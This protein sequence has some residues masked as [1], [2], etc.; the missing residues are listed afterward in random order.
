M[1]AVLLGI[2]LLLGLAGAAPAQTQTPAAVNGCIYYSSLP[3][4]AN[5]QR[6][7]FLC[8]V[9]GKLLTTGSGGGGSGTVTSVGW[10][11]GLVS[12]ATPTTTPAFTVAGTSGG[13]PYFSSAS[14]WASSA[15]LAANALVVGGGAGVAP[16]TTTTGTGVLTALGLTANGSGAIS[17]TTSPAFVTPALGVATATTLAVG[18]ATIGAN[19][20]AVTGT[21]I[22]SGN[23]TAGALLSQASVVAGATGTY[24]WTSRTVLAS[25]SDGTLRLTNAAGTSFTCAQLGGTSASFPAACR[26]GTTFQIRLADNSADAPLTAAAITSSATINTGGYVVSGLPAGTIGMRAYVTDQ[27][28]A[29]A[30]TG[31]AL[32][33]GGAVVCPTFYNG[34][35]WVG[36]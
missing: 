9:N 3:T 2:F 1:R 7:S 19:A 22:F 27:L 8:D 17:L 21:A 31:A 34:S 6:N 30:V 26:S 23:L 5:G 35:A 25:L 16:A 29:C 36:G 15:A 11:G 12:V 20:F 4:L 28:T 13:V 32:T 24:S 33:G 18:G 10:T 14:T